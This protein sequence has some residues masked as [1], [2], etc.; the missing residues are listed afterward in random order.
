MKVEKEVPRF[1]VLEAYSI[2][3][4]VHRNMP[5]LTPYFTEVRGQKYKRQYS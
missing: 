3:Y 4:P 2:T 5:N 1:R